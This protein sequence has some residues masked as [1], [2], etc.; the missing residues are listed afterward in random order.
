MPH[1]VGV[2]DGV[3]LTISLCLTYTLCISCVRAWIRKGAFG[4]DDIVV[5]AA[6]VVSFVHTGADYAALANGLGSPWKSI[7][8]SDNLKALN[9]VSCMLHENTAGWLM[10]HRLL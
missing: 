7:L 3:N 5:A 10:E 6:T 8:E 4:V 9:S 2:V 1:H